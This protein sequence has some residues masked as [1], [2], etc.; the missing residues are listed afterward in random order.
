MDRTIQLWHTTGSC[1]NYATLTSHKGAVLDLHWSRDG[2]VLYSCSSDLTIQS[3]DLSTG[4]RIRRHQGHEEVVNC[5]DVS[6]RGEEFLISGSDDGYIGLWDPRRKEALDYIKTEYPVTAVCMSEAGNEVFSGGIDNTIHV[7]DL[8]QKKIVYN[9]EGHNDT[10]TSLSLSPDQQTLLSFSHDS[11]AR[12][13][14]IRPFAPV[15]R[16]IRVFDGA[17][18]GLEKNLMRACWDHEGKRVAAGGGDGT[19]T[20]WEGRSG[21]MV[22]KLPGHRGTVNCVGVSP[23]GSMIVSA[24]TD[25]RVLVGEF[26][27]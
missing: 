10:I 14:D 22:Q 24:S 16:A 11:T 5:I 26:G 8:R 4:A 18:V 15:D 12:T 2:G 21:K 19:V 6:K 25:R 13:W 20:V 27:R 7:W 17:Q 9:L 1:A 23:D 3:H